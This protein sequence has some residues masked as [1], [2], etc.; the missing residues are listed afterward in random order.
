MKSKWNEEEAARLRAAAGENEADQ[1]LAMRVYTSRL[2]GQDPELVMH[3]GGNTSVKVTRTDLWG[4]EVDVLHVKGSGWDLGSIEAAGLPAVRMAPL[5]ELR[6]RESLSDE[7]MVSAQRQNLLDPS[8]PN[9]SVETL[10]HAFLPHRFIDHTHATASLALANQPDVHRLCGELFG[11]R[12]ALVDYIMPGFALSKAA[13]AVYEANP[14]VEGLLLVNHG[15]FTFGATAREAYE[16]MIDHVNAMEGL[17]EPVEPRS[18]VSDAL[19]AT[20]LLPQLRGAL[21]NGDGRMPILDLRTSSATRDF[22]DRADV[23]ELATR[24]VATPDHVIRTKRFPIVLR[25]EPAEAVG[26]FRE[27]YT[28]YFERQSTRVPGRTMLAP[29]PRVF[30]VP[31]LGMIG[32]GQTRNAASVAADLAEQTARVISAAESI[33]SFDPVGE[34]D[35]FDMEYWSLEQ[36]KLGKRTVPEFAG[37][38]V[39]VT[40]AAGAIGAATARA[41]HRLGASVFLVDR[42]ADALAAVG[43]ELGASTFVCDLTNEDGPAHALDA[44]VLAYGGIDIVVSNAGAA[45][46][47]AIGEVDESVLRASFELNF[48]AHQRLAQAAV[49]VMKVQGQGGQLLFNVSKQAVNPG[50]DFGPYGLAKAACLFLVKQYAVDHGADGIRSNGVNADRIRSGLLTDSMIENRSSARGLSEEQYMSGN[51]LQREVTADDVAEAFVA[52]ARARSTS[53]HIV[54]VDGGNIAASLR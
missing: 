26:A 45:W 32:V 39:A 41:F 38:I 11:D 35:T 53:G 46:T 33:G 27:A 1:L 30:W 25:G 28:A 36:A 50:R 42:D 34:D 40:G 18:P 4:R 48:W 49:R 24:G 2:I 16:R 21:A 51:L 12:V 19:P 54:T 15:H 20:A 10:L 8:A 14:H 31:G 47:G 22:V 7:D 3:G 6:E 13:A 29:D 17:F 52:L 43:D 44:C 23:N 5:L 37:R 9:P